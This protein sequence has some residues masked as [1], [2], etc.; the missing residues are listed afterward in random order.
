MKKILVL[1]GLLSVLTSVK[2]ETWVMPNQGG[3]E[4]TLSSDK[5]K[6]DGGKY[7]ALKHAYS[8]TNQIYFEGCW[9]LQD[10]NIHIIW[11]FTDGTRERRV[12]S[13]NSFNKK[14]N[15]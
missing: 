5:C 1:L 4:I 8:W 15:Y 9:L 7:T 2:A 10:G 6:A 12:Y 14:A 3:G 13:I 11:V